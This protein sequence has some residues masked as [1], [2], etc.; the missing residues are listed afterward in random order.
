MKHC[1]TAIKKAFQKDTKEGCP[2]AISYHPVFGYF[3]IWS[4][5]QGPGLGKYEDK[6]DNK[7]KERISKLSEEQKKKY[8]L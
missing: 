1:P 4:A 3:H 5:G 7:L 6:D 2:S 8:L